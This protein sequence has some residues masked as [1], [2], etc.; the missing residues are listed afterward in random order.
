MTGAARGLTD[1]HNHLVPGV[2]DG[3][4]TLEDAREGLA[5]LQASGLRQVVT[6]PHL[7]GSLTRS[8]GL[9]AERFEEVDRA[10]NT[11]KALVDL[12]FPEM[13][14]QRGHEVMLDVPDPDLS[15][16]RLRLAG[17]RYV[18]VEWQ[19]LS[20][21]P[22]TGAVLRRLQ[23]SGVRPIVAH[24]ERYRG[25][26]RDVYLP[27]EWREEGALL[28]VNYGSLVGRYGDL[29]RKR[30]FTLLERG[31]VDLMASDYHGRPH[32]APFLVE[33]REQLSEVGGGG[34]FGLLAGVNP[35]RV[36]RGDDPLPVPP[37]RKTPG[38]W[39]R[40]RN[41]FRSRERR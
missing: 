28:Q 13:E 4:R 17:T 41:V 9:L 12:E 36:L 35:S 5:R 40:L 19:G 39:E 11:L 1:L 14:I 10:W 18:L 33:A 38:P 34:Q 16:P 23:E 25:V 24:P 30:A 29:A 2:D 32:L 3:S 8:A 37:L 7:D 26:D 27:G 20:V 21:P 6:T 31:W 15:D 22:S